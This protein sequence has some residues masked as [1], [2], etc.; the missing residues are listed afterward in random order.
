MTPFAPRSLPF[1]LFWLVSIWV[2]WPDGVLA[3]VPSPTAQP[4]TLV[5][6]V[7]PGD[8]LRRI[9]LRYRNLTRHYTLGELLAD[10]WAANGLQSDL[11]RPGQTLRIPLGKEE[12]PP[13]VSFPVAEGALF[14]GIYLTGPLCASSVLFDRVDRFVAAGGNGVVF[15]AKDI[16]G[17]VTFR[18]RHSWAQSGEDRSAPLIPNLTD[19]IRRLHARRLFVV[20]RLALFLDGGLGRCQP[21]LAL[22]DSSGSAWTE[23]GQ[24]WM[25]PGQAQVRAYNAALATELAAAGVDEIQLD[26]LRYPTNG[27][28]HASDETRQEEANRRCRAITQYL[29]EMRDALA[30]YPV[31]ISADLFGVMGWES[32]ADLAII[33][34]D[35]AAIA[36]WVDVLC[37]MLYP[38]H[39][40]A[41]FAGFDQPADHPTFFVAEGCRRFAQLAKGQAVVRP[42]LQAFPLGVGD[43]CGG[44][45]LAQIA[46]AKAAGANGWCLWNPAGRY[47]LALEALG[48]S[49]NRILAGATP[50]PK[51]PGD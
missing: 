48:S 20:A 43:F 42:W 2:V 8:S 34:Q 3:E 14:K 40:S 44:Y 16:D 19:F 4:D 38:S 45:V 27:S 39:F 6:V 11:L 1:A 9:A 24:V 13:C 7:Q 46:G 23:Q 29:Q 31:L 15:D 12:T 17:A 51:P 32:V 25:D 35:V 47:D 26:Y 28:D 37:P 30:G 18:S 49:K 10:I 50:Q 5:H 33:G 41:G 22:R 21:Q 36:R